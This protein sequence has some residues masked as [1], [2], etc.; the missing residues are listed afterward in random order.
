MKYAYYYH[1]KVSGSVS[2]QMVLCCV[3]WLDVEV[4]F[5]I[6]IWKGGFTKNIGSV[7]VYMIELWSVYEGLCLARRQGFTNNELQVD[8]FVV[9]RSLG[10]EEI[11]TC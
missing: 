6:L 11:V 3:V 10:G 8:S 9:V 1:L 5:V 4:S 2:T 7:S